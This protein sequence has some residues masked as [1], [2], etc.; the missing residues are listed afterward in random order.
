LHKGNNTPELLLLDGF[1][2]NQVIYMTIPS[3]SVN[4]S[5]A[6][7]CRPKLQRAAAG[8]YGWDPGV[9]AVLVQAGMASL[10][11]AALTQLWP[12]LQQQ[13]TPA[14]LLLNRSASML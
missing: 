7:W 2:L 8:G 5:L 14:L 11:V 1:S 12:P 10:A 4:G 3:V 9:V 6:A 13:P